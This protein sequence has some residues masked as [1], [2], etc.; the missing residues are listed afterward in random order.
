MARI[1]SA[2]EDKHF[3]NLLKKPGQVLLT[4]GQYRLLGAR[5]VVL[6][7]EISELPMLPI[8]TGLG[9][10]PLGESTQLE[11]KY[12]LA[13][14]GYMLEVA[15]GFYNN[16]ISLEG[17]TNTTAILLVEFWWWLHRKAEYVMR[18]DHDKKR[19]CTRILGG[20]LVSYRKILHD[21]DIWSDRMLFNHLAYAAMRCSD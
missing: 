10:E 17:R 21:A 3:G 20:D 14:I 4:P 2:S 7:K 12:G 1:S 16:T 5:I 11:V 18:I 15:R 13:L 9:I 6:L 19:N 8:H